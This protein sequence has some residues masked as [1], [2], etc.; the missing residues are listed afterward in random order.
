MT[1]AS[2]TSYLTDIAEDKFKPGTISH[3]RGHPIEEKEEEEERLTNAL[4]MKFWRKYG[5]DCFFSIF[6]KNDFRK[7]QIN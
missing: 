1:K 5:F 7:G 3:K 6:V 4:Q 2:E